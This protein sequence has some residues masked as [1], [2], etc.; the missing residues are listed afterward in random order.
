MAQTI[1]LAD[2]N[3]RLRTALRGSA[4]RI[5]RVSCTAMIEKPPGTAIGSEMLPGG[6]L[7]NGRSNRFGQLFGADPAEVAADRAGRA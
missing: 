7:A 1:Y 2:T 3:F 6:K 4:V 5:L